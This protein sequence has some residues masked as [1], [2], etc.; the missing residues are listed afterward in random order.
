MEQGYTYILTN[1]NDTVFYVG[2]TSNIQRRLYE[3]RN[4]RF[5][6]FTD[7]YNVTKVVYVELTERI[8]DA[9]LR[10]KQLKG[11]SRAKKKRLIESI[12]PDYR[13]LYNDYMK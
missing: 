13:D 11:W 3:H 9:I 4:H 12:N 5:R 2:V 1:E 6:G 7:R 8:E 10:E